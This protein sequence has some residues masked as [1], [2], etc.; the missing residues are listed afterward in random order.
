[1]GGSPPASAATLAS[2]TWTASGTTTGSSVVSYTYTVMATTT[3]TL[4]KVTMTVPSGISGTPAVGTVTPAAIATGASVSI[5][6]TTLSYTFT[7]ASVT[8]GSVL[9]IQI[10]GL[11]NTFASGSQTSTI[12]TYNGTTAVDSGTAGFTFTGTALSGVG[13][14]PTSTVEGAS[15]SYTYTFKP[16]SVLTS[17]ITEITI[18]IPPGTTG[19]PTI[20]S[21]SPSGL[22]SSLTGVTLSGNLLTI[23]GSG[24]TLSLGASVSIQINGLTNTYTAGNYV[25]EIATYTTGLLLMDSGVAAASFSAGLIIAAPASL[26]WSGALTGPIQSLA[27]TAAT[28]EQLT[29][30]DQTATGAGWHITAAAT[31]FTNGG[32]S[33]PDTSVLDV[34][35]SVTNVALTTA[36]TATCLASAICTLPN[37]SSVTYPVTITSAAVSPTPQTIYDSSANTGIGPVIIGGSTAANPVGWWVNVPG[38]AAIGTYTSTVTVS[39]VSGP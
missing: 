20:G 23:V 8:A 27:D 32:Y 3:S 30:N 10:T 35:G 29:L 28:D 34:T 15:A 18:S 6:G 16:S 7:A 9:S 31:S 24:F 39:V 33:L 14:S 38:D 37:D 12:T 4:S 22:L 13:W 11:K 5:A 1:M 26:T 21:V 36:P 19:T 17:L 25:A 2:A